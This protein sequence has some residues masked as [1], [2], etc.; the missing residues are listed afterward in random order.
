MISIII[1]HHDDCDLL[2]NTLHSIFEHNHSISSNVT[3]IINQM[4]NSSESTEFIQNEINKYPKKIILHNTWI[5]SISEGYQKAMDFVNS[6]YVL[7]AHS[8]DI[9]SMPGLQHAFEYFE[10]NTNKFHALSFHT[11]YET[12]GLS[13]IFPPELLEKK[14]GITIS[15]IEN[16]TCIPT[17][18]YGCL[19]LVSSLNQIPF[20]ITMT[21]DFGLNT[22]YRLL[23][24][25]PF[26]GYVSDAKYTSLYIPM[27]Y[28][29]NRQ[30]K[31][32]YFQ[33]LEKFLLPLFDY[34][35]L[36]YNTIPDF[37]Q[38]A[39]TYQLKW[40]FNY[41]ANNG[42]KHIIDDCL[43]DFFTLCTKILQNISDQVLFNHSLN[44]K[45]NMS[46][47]LK[48]ALI[49]LKYNGNCETEIISDNKSN[50]L[51][52]KLN[53]IE[54]LNLETQNVY[55][56]L[57]EYQDDSL[58]IEASTNNFLGFEKLLISASLNNTLLEI[59]KTYRYAHNKFFGISTHKRN[60]FRLTIPVEWL[61][62]HNTLQFFFQ[63][64]N[65]VQPL[66]IA[67]LN[68]NAKVD[69]RVRNAYW[70]FKRKYLVRYK[71][72]SKMLS[73]DK[74]ARPK[75]F[76]QEMKMLLCMLHGPNRSRNMFL[77]RILYWLTHPFMKHKTIWLTYDKLFKGGDCGEY[78]YRYMC[79]KK[80]HI[81]PAYVINENST[82]YKRL[83]EE[84]YHPLRYG[85]LKHRLYYANS[86]VVFT[87]HGGVH[88]FNAFTNKQVRFIEGLLHHDVACIQHGLT[89]QQLAFNSN[90]LFNNMKRY[91]C[92]SK[93]EIQNLSH[94]IY[95]YENKSILKLTGIPRYDG[96]V[97]Q[98]KK[99]IL[100]TPTWRNYIAM[101]AASKNNAKPYNPDFINTDYFKIY[102]ELLQDEKLIQISSETGYKIIYL[103]HPVISAQINDYPKH[104]G[105]E[106]LPALD[107]NYEKI[108]TESSLMV[109]DYSGVQFDFAYMRKPIVYYHPPK[110]PPHYKEGGFFYDTM[111][112]G[113]I[114]TTHQTLVDT[115]CEYM[116]N[117]C[118]VKPFYH[119]RQDDFFAFSD[120][121]SCQRI[122]SDMMEYQSFKD[123]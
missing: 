38:Y 29:S 31:E 110:L 14:N 87:T 93:Y 91:Y 120:L 90:R 6:K 7:F 57:M 92:A 33:F 39:A 106:I 11:E 44:P 81:T 19:F 99:Q 18:I 37:I 61:N 25:K 10:A 70:L 103:L 42:N 53:K 109:T 49:H 101:P 60:T 100:I 22:I 59:E 69:T 112:F 107:I 119:A 48:F 80:D 121:N 86:S 26:L 83:K 45:Y 88:S 21:Y 73:I 76:F 20:D 35:Q 67:S 98:D 108:L 63:Y 97:N 71:S 105:I 8:G 82:D 116:Q 64:N 78:L 54:I 111:G 43:D 115:L 65:M 96:L 41:N 34:Y 46:L 50:S 66:T 56:E 58:I 122:Y 36:K 104:E 17:S 55:I 95:G 5:S 74:V 40:R 123:N 62:H 94:P 75:V 30:E 51:V 79:T 12:P 27:E 52:M 23:A 118:T 89:V 1:A 85:S 84:G 3:V 16:P 28:I 9:I 2:K 102:N 117:N 4:V 113:E 47:P 68:Y 13:T 72:D 15:L 114:C 77:F 32:W 24:D